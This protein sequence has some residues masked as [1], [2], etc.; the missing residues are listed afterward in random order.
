MTNIEFPKCPICLQEIKSDATLTNYCGL[1]GMAIEG[2]DRR[3]C[4][5]ICESGLR[6]IYKN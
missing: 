5:K 1:C 4:C 6:M 2:N 3:F